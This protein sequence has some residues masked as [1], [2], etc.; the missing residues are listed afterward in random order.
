MLE[1]IRLMLEH[2][3]LFAMSA[4]W[5]YRFWSMP[6]L[7][8]ER[9]VFNILTVTTRHLA[10]LLGNLTTFDAGARLFDLF[11]YS[12]T[13]DWDGS[14]VAWDLGSYLR[15]AAARLSEQ[16]PG[17]DV[18]M[19]RLIAAIR[20]LRP[21]CVK[22][23]DIRVA[24]ERIGLPPDPEYSDP[25]WDAEDFNLPVFLSPDD[26]SSANEE[27][28]PPEEGEMQVYAVPQDCL[29]LHYLDAAMR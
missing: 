8:T 20:T 16:D 3:A 4:T 9:G 11:S 24:W 15:A 18:S 27:P 6:P 1:I 19:H 25:F 22:R 23:D 29:T 5:Q 21:F 13:K 10:R 2:A 14:D 26:P 28:S 12:E 7:T 17:T